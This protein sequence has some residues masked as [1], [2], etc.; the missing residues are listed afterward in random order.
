MQLEE[1]AQ[2]ILNRLSSLSFDECY[3]LSREFR[4]MPTMG[5]LYAVRHRTEGVLYIGLAVGLRRRFRDNG[6]KAF[7]WAFLDCYSPVDICIA[8]EL[9]TIQTFRE[10]DQLETLM[11]QSAQPRYNVRKK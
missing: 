8:V 6:H 1:E 2:T 7:F 9:L 10:G 5:G 4:D 11:I 3:P